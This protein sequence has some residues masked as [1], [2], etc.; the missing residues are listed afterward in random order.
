MR[1]VIELPHEQATLSAGAALAKHC[2]GGL[3]IYLQ[4]DLGAGK[5]TLVR[6]FL[7]ALGYTGIVK[8]PTYTL[9]E[10]YFL[11]PI[12]LHH[13][14]L[15]RLSDPEELDYIGWIDY[16]TSEN[17]CIIEW[18]EKGEGYLPT[19]DLDGMLLVTNSGMSRQ[20][21]WQANSPLGQR[22]LEHMHL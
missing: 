10:S 19:A 17:C 6:G 1:K 8:S 21:I 12:T 7:R 11:Q 4:G 13:F 20:L 3:L 2:C 22:I 5:T 9:V 18:P 16:C 14:D 15:Y